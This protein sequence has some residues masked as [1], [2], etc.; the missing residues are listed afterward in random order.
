MVTPASEKKAL[1][2][3]CLKTAAWNGSGDC[4]NDNLKM[5]PCKRLTINK[6]LFLT[7]PRVAAINELAVIVTDYTTITNI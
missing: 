6:T 5:Y 3:T 1:W 7:L 2:M 4:R